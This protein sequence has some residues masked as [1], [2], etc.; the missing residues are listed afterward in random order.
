M[1]TTS[2]AG[3]T[4]NAG[5]RARQMRR[6]ALLGV[7]VHMMVGLLYGLVLGAL[8]MRGRFAAA[9]SAA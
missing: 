4:A 1:A 8:L 6:S 3:I 2:S 5:S 9:M 7:V